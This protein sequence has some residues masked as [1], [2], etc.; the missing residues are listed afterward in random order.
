MAFQDR[1]TRAVIMCTRPYV[2]SPTEMA[3][4]KVWA[5]AHENEER[6]GTA[7]LLP[8]SRHS[9]IGQIAEQL[10]DARAVQRRG[11]RQTRRRR[12]GKFGASRSSRS[13]R[14]GSSMAVQGRAENAGQSV[15]GSRRNTRPMCVKIWYIAWVAVYMTMAPWAGRMQ[16]P[17]RAGCG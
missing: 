13:R 4:I 17:W 6:A 9:A 15:A 11:V 3:C 14:S 7:E 8:T 5:E 1:D 10:L 12:T 2:H 16:R